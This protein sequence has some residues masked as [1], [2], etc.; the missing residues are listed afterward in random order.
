MVHVECEHLSIS[1]YPSIMSLALCDL[2]FNRINM[3]LGF[4]LDAQTCQK[5]IDIEPVK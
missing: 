3:R 1:K 4:V 2:I 5:K